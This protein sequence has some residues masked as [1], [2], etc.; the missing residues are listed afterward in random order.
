MVAKW[1]E[2]ISYFGMATPKSILPLVIRGSYPAGFTFHQEIVK[3]DFIWSTQKP[4][5]C[6][7]IWPIITFLFKIHK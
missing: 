7:V 3:R 5:K 2:L 1:P 4:V 6:F